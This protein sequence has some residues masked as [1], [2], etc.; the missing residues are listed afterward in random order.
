MSCQ[1]EEGKLFI[2]VWG[3]RLSGKTTFIETLKSGLG[4]ILRDNVIIDECNQS[5]IPPRKLYDIIMCI[6]TS[7]DLKSDIV[8]K[9]DN[10]DYERYIE[11]QNNY[12]YELDKSK[13]DIIVPINNTYPAA[14]IDLLRSYIAAKLPQNLP[15]ECK[16]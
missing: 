13:A 11:D 4:D 7:N 2:A 9:L 1:V 3:S 8:R 12:M 15:Q 6:E 14:I 16:K 5:C 10:A